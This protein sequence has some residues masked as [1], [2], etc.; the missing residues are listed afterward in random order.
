M[1]HRVAQFA[2][3]GR[4]PT[5]R[6][7]AFARE[8]LAPPLYDL[9]AA[10]HPRDIVHAAEC[11]R[12]LV[13]RGMSNADLIAAA[14]LH[15]IGKGPQRRWDR[16]AAVLA[17]A[18]DLSEVAADADSRFELRRALQRTVD[19]SREGARRL[20][21]AGAPEAVA[22][23]TRL[24]HSLPAGAGGDGMLALLQQADAVT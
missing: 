13:H 15:D 1:L 2:G 4:R 21:A 12:W 22:E 24:H 14:L 8:R 9:F 19:H 3:A 18:L 20:R 11:A 17:D 7:Y 5:A 10:Q 6:D 23:L 16:A